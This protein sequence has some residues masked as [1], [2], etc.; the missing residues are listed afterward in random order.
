M[1]S[2][3][4]LYTASARGQIRSCNCTKFRFGGY[5]REQTLVKSIREKCPD[6]VLLEGG[7]STSGTTPQAGLKADVTATALKLLGYGA[8][9]PGEEELGVRGTSFMS[10]FD[11]NSVPVICANLNRP[12]AGQPR[13]QALRGSHDKE[14]ASRR[15]YRNNRRLDNRCARGSEL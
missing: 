6:V 7:D 13:V 15:S 4:L 2:L 3:V 5:G 12:A 11:P 9:V 10:H 14:R 8:M 1:R